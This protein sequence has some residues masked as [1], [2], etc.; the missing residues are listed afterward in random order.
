MSAILS[1]LQCGKEQI[2]LHTLQVTKHILKRFYNLQ[3]KYFAHFIF[4][5]NLM[6]WL[7]FLKNTPQ[8][9][10]FMEYFS[11]KDHYNNISNITWN[12]LSIFT[13]CHNI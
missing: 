2:N 11:Y 3:N 1:Q 10:T 8:D 4:C 5:K 7:K 13:K 9:I 12:L 6:I